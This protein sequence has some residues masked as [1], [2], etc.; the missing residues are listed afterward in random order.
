M[1]SGTSALALAFLALLT[2]T[3]F[4]VAAP[5]LAAQVPVWTLAPDG[6]ELAD[7]ARPLHRVVD[8]AVLAD[9]TIALADQGNFRIALFDQ[10]GSLV[11]SLGREGAGPAEFR[12]LSGVYAVGDTILGYDGLL[13]RVSVWTGDGDALD[14]RRL[15]AYGGNDT[16]LEAVV[17]PG[18]WVVGTRES[19]MPE[20]GGAYNP[21]TTLLDFDPGTGRLDVV[22]RKRSGY[23]YA[24]IDEG[25]ITG[26]RLG[27]FGELQ[28]AATPSAVVTLPLDSAGAHVRPI[29]GE[30][31]RV[32]PLPIEP[33]PFR[34]EVITSHR[35]SLLALGNFEMF[36]G[37]RERIQRVYTE[38]LAA[39]ARAPAVARALSLGEEVWIQVAPEPEAEV[40]RWFVLDPGGPEILARID[41]PAELRL[42]GGDG[43]TVI[44]RAV[45]ELGVE[46]VY[47]RRVQ[48]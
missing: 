7:A 14:T 26:Y 37:A 28:V 9:G 32:V 22:E 34:S 2:T 38:D 17:S 12:G 31:F 44:L 13:R 47:A 11:R 21:S 1:R 41:L 35:D 5:S 48:R 20:G 15:P 27:F 4:S 3:W 43:E 16:G 30:E 19:D 6:I 8:A 42:L 40:H 45:D 29:G 24:Y 36:P 46:S 18:R 39:P 23:R 33:R 10:A 25:G